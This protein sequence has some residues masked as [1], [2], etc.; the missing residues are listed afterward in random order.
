[1]LRTYHS[2]N[3]LLYSPVKIHFEKANDKFKLMEKG[4][5]GSDIIHREKNLVEL[6]LL[7]ET[8]LLF[9]SL[10]GSN[11]STCITDYYLACIFKNGINSSDAN[12]IIWVDTK[13]FLAKY[14]VIPIY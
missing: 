9:R 3:L 13:S 7:S 10:L 4:E 8:F 2:L 12:K 6:I 14:S 11:V 5:K 1:M